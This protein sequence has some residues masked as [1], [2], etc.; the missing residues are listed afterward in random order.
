M[1]SN[2]VYLTLFNP[3]FPFGHSFCICEYNAAQLFNRSTFFAIVMAYFTNSFDLLLMKTNLTCWL[4]TK[5]TEEKIKQKKHTMSHYVI[6]KELQIDKMNDV[7]KMTR[8]ENKQY[9]TT[10]LCIQFYFNFY[11]AESGRRY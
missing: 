1:Q 9:K 11:I 7:S 3:E 10:F 4:C 5:C 6:F 2:L 8:L